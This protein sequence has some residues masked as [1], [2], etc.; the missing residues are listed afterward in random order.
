MD[1]KSKAAER[2]PKKLRKEIL[3]NDLINL[4]HKSVKAEEYLFDM[5]EH[6]IDGGQH[7]DFNCNICRVFVLSQ[8]D[9]L[10]PYLENLEN[11]DN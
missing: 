4:A 11:E 5:Y 1:L 7:N 10:K 3:E 6:F 2:I 9:N 8:W